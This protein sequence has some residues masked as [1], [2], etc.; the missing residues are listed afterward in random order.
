MIFVLSQFISGVTTMPTSGRSRIAL[1]FLWVGII[2]ILASYSG[3]LISYLAVDVRRLPFTSLRQVIL[4]PSYD[5]WMD[6]KSVYAEIFHVR[7][8]TYLCSHLGLVLH[9]FRTP[10]VRIHMHPYLSIL[11]ITSRGHRKYSIKPKWIRE[12]TMVGSIL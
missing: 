6:T 9:I 11:L 4:S 10:Y 3:T 8:Y 5:I 7:I 12:L 2:V 1:S